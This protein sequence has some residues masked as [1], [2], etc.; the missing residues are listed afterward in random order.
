M[1]RLPM[2][3]IFLPNHISITAADYYPIGEAPSDHRAI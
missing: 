2:D 1:G 3:G